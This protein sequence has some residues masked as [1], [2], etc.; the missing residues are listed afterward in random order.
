[1]SIPIRMQF[2]FLL[3]LQPVFQHRPRHSPD[4]IPTGWGAAGGF[5]RFV[6]R[7]EW[8]ALRGHQP[9]S[10]H[11]RRARRLR[12]VQL[13]QQEILFLGQMNEIQERVGDPR[14]AAQQ[15]P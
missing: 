3:L 8:R 14:Q 7:V 12:A 4:P 2:L 15:G 1:M 9:G 5:A 6:V 10:R 13:A 11:L